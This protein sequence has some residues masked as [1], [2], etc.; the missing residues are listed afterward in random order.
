MLYKILESEAL[1]NNAEEEWVQN[2]EQI[3]QNWLIC[4]GLL[5]CTIDKNTQQRAMAFFDI[6]VDGGHK[7]TN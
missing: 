1:K 7:A 3:D 4:L 6:V 2:Q 5:Y